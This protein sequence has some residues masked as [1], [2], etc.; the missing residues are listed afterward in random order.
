MMQSG[1]LSMTPVAWRCSARIPPLQRRLHRR[2]GGCQEECPAA[3]PAGRLAAAARKVGASPRG[4]GASSRQVPC[5]QVVASPWLMPC[6]GV[7]ASSRGVGASPSVVARVVGLWPRVAGL[8]VSWVAGPSADAEDSLPAPARRCHAARGASHTASLAARAPR[9]RDCSRAPLRASSRRW[10]SRGLP[11]CG[12]VLS[13][14][15]AGPAAC[16]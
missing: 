9:A 10:L 13:R 5:S 7:V 11:P 3:P 6:A 12:P 16:S 2:Q 14:R 1:W 4:V 15:R 8:V